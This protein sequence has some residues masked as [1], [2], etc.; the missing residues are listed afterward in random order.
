MSTPMLAVLVLIPTVV[1]MIAILTMLWRERKS[2]RDGATVVV[3]GVVLTAWVAIAAWLAAR[4]FLAP[5]DT[6]SV[7]PVG[8]LLA[9]VL[10]GLAL[11]LV[12]FPSLRGLLTR[13]DSLIR[14]NVWRLEGLVFLALMAYGQVPA[15]WALPAGIGDVI[16]G[17]TAP[18]VARSVGTPHG[19]ARAI[20]FNLFGMTDLIVAVGLG[21]MTNPGPTQV[22]HTTPTSELLTRFPLA[23]VPT[24]LVPL[25]FT[26][27]VISL[28]QLFGWPW[29]TGESPRARSNDDHVHL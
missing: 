20:A 6:P 21:V 2:P 29:A 11:L 1:V 17:A 22:F 10:P 12:S 13:Q 28:W 15:L 9:L 25:A 8:V 4:G 19:R 14:L 23:L 26:L 27:H 18:R 5:P 3:A 24:F 7:P 16:V